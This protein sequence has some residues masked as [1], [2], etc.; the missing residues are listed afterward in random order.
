[1]VGCKDR[2][3]IS[4]RPL[5]RRTRLAA[6]LIGGQIGDFGDHVGV[7]QV[8]KHSHHHQ[9]ADRE[10]VAFEPLLVAKPVGDS[11]ELK[12][13]KFFG[14]RP[15]QLRPFLIGVEDG[16]REDVLDSRL[17][18]VERGVGPLNCAEFRLRIAWKKR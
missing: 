7:P 15:A 14:A 17:D 1:M 12:P 11:L 8:P 16:N 4:Q 5:K 13:D 9:I 10:A 6:L 3:L 2:E 18:A